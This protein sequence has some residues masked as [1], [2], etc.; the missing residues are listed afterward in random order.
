MS[1][2][3]PDLDEVTAL[4]LLY[5]NGL[6]KGDDPIH[7]RSA[8]GASILDLYWEAMKAHFNCAN[9]HEALNAI[10]ELNEAMNKAVDQAQSLTG[11]LNGS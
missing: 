7:I 8:L 9:K 11:S 2:H 1:I 4:N 3:R 10:L 5:A 6:H